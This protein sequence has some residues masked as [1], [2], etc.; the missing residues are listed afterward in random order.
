[1]SEREYIVGLDEVGRGAVAGP[2]VVGLVAIP[3]GTKLP[4]RLGRLSLRDSK[5]LSPAGREAW[6]KWLKEN[7]Q[8]KNWLVLSSRVY[9]S[10]IDRIN[11]SRAASEAA[12]RLYR[13]ASRKLSGRLLFF[14]DGGLYLKSRVCQRELGRL[15]FGRHFFRTEIRADE[16]IKVVKLASIAAKVERDRYMGRQ[17]GCYPGYGFYRHKGYGT[18]DHLLAIR[19]NGV[20]PL[21]RLTFIGRKNI[22][23]RQKQS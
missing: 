14:L 7:R 6:S 5:Q 10:R 17:D 18:V 12:Y 23:K 15:N 2:V 22:I 13:R 11:I 21:H 19:K 9:S 16:K 1:M 20:C 8:G 4:D 3:R